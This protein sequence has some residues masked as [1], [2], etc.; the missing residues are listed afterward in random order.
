MLAAL[1]LSP[2]AQAYVGILIGI[3]AATLGVPIPEEV[4]LL[5]AGVLAALGV[6][7]LRWAIAFGIFACF[8]GDVA[9]FA[10]ARRVR[11]G[12]SRFGFVKRLL[13]GR[14]A[15]KARHL[16]VHRGPWALVVARLLPGLKMPFLLTAGAFRMPW[17]RFLFYDLCSVLL[18]VPTLVLVAYH[19]S[20]SLSQLRKL[21][22]EAGLI[23]VP[24]FLLALAAGAWWLVRASRR[25]KRQRA[26]AALSGTVPAAPSGAP[27]ARDPYARRT[28]RSSSR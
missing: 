4:T 8:S 21:V 7:D 20:F 16:Y 6:I 13:R 28:R 17:G 24:L 11:A 19:S 26:A 2:A 22:T 9:L 5:T 27:P 12:A 10:L 25:R 1:N 3:W 23:L 14:H 18:L 15:R